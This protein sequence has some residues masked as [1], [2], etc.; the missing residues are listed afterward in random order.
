MPSMFRAIFAVLALAYLASA[1]GY[2]SSTTLCLFKGHPKKS[3]GETVFWLEQEYNQYNMPFY[4]MSELGFSEFKSIEV[5]LNDGTKDSALIYLYHNREA[6]TENVAFVNYDNTAYHFSGSEKLDS[7]KFKLVGGGKVVV[8]FGSCVT[9][10]YNWEW[11]VASTTV[12][13]AGSIKRPKTFE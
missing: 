5:A 3:P 11:N 7:E 13:A 2:V 4:T 1:D 6:T 8:E 12:A 10:E 9:P